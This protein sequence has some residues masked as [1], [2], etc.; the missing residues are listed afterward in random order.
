[1]KLYELTVILLGLTNA[2][3]SFHQWVNELL[4]KFWDVSVL[5]YIDNILIHSEKVYSHVIHVPQVVKKLNKTAVKL[6]ISKC[7]FDT[8]LK[9]NGL[10]KRGVYGP[11]VNPSHNQMAKSCQL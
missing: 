2:P 7:Q 6:R 4:S 8:V 1:M 3:G 9:I 11:Q 5:I 10:A